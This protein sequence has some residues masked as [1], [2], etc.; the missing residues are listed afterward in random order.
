MALKKVVLIS[1]LEGYRTCRLDSLAAQVAIDVTSQ[2]TCIQTKEGESPIIG[3]YLVIVSTNPFLN[4]NSKSLL[5]SNHLQLTNLNYFYFSI[6]VRT[7]LEMQKMSFTNIMLLKVF[8][9]RVSRANI[10]LVNPCPSQ[11]QLC[12]IYRICHELTVEIEFY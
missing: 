6:G 9:R 4:D 2:S 5:S 12:K 1:G 10:C 7:I 11:F 8:F 3:K